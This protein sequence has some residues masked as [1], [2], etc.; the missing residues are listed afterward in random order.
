MG[1]VEQG[2]RELSGCSPIFVLGHHPLDW[3]TPTDAKRIRAML[4][5]SAAIYLH[6]HLHKSE[7]LTQS[8]GITPV[9]ALQCGCAFFARNDEKQLTRLLWGGYE[10]ATQNILVRPKKWMQD[11]HEWALDTDAFPESLRATG[12][13]YWIIPTRF[14]NSNVVSTDGRARISVEHR[15]PPPEG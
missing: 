3:M 15:I 10:N 8:S 4:A 11:D 1:M 14:R 13:D 9:V 5:K 2:L 7:H 6:G 12:R